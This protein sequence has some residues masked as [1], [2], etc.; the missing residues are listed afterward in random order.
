M[1][2]KVLV[3]FAATVV[4]AAGGIGLFALLTEGDTVTAQ[5]QSRPPQPECPSKR[6]A[7]RVFSRTGP[8]G[9]FETEDAAARDEAARALKGYDRL[10]REQA[11]SR[12][13]RRAGHVVARKDGRPVA[14]FVINQADNDRYTVAKVLLC[15]EDIRADY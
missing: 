5:S 2:T 4:L 13:E 8:E 9:E 14:T 3:A 10:D 12:P 15:L 7:T 11:A 6:G 1:R